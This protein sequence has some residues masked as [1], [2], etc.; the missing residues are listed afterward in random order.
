MCRS[1]AVIYCPKLPL[2][3]HGTLSTDK[4]VYDKLVIVECNTGFK[5]ADN[6]TSKTVLCL[7]STT[8]NDSVVECQGL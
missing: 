7:D 4:T 3:L 6:R 8:W 5:H 2:L 1:V